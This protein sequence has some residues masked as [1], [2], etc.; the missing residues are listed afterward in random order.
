MSLQ[1]IIDG[2]NLINHPLYNR[3][4]HS[5]CPAA[6]LAAF[7]R[8]KRLTGSL[9]NRVIL[10]FDGF[11]PAQAPAEEEG[12][13]GIIFSRKISADEK[14][15]MLV[16]SSSGRKAI[17]VVSDDRQIGFVSK[18]LGAKVIG[19]EEFIRGKKK[20]GAVPKEPAKPGL[21]YTQ[22]ERINE[23]LREKWLR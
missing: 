2:Y 7:I 5:L 8:E 22:L 9:K 11:G 4:K 12:H 18:A 17:V 14:I 20:E 6:A 19:I 13:I 3:K 10:V 15:K 16:E 1:F 23:E 21:T